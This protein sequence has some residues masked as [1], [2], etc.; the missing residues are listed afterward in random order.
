MYF[1]GQWLR[2]EQGQDV[3]EYTLLLAFV[4][5]MSAALFLTNQTYVAH[6]WNSSSDT[7]AEG[8]H[9]IQ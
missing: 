2:D 6:I 1:I 4:V 9:L 7:L 3:T 8:N 5:L